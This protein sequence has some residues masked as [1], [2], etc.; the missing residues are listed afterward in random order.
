MTN[1]YYDQTALMSF[2]VSVLSLATALAVPGGA[3]EVSAVALVEA[4]QLRDLVDRRAA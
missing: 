1:H 2:H 3:K 4:E